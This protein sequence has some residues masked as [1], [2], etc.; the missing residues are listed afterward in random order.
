MVSLNQ[1]VGMR[2]TVDVTKYTD[3]MEFVSLLDLKLVESRQIYCNE[4]I[5]YVT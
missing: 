3:M 4:S 5:N 1:S 2:D